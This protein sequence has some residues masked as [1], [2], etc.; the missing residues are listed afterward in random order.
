MDTRSDQFSRFFDELSKETPRGC[1]IVGAAY[2]D[3]LI[4]QVLE[5]YLLENNDAKNDLIHSKNTSAPLGSFGSRLTM[6]Y[7]IG[8]IDKDDLDILRTIKKIRNKFAHD[9]DISFDSQSIDSLC[10]TLKLRATEVKYSNDNPEK[11]EIYQMVVSYFF[12]RFTQ[13]LYSIKEYGLTASYVSVLRK[14]A[15]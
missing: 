3:A 7:A 9:L 12:G 6:S 5:L 13:Q 14:S 10:D 1:V 15:S 8:L 2:L 11:R 4:G